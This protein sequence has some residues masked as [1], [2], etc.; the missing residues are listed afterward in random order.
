MPV[1]E[2]S[3]ELTYLL[4]HTVSSLKDEVTC[5]RSLGLLGLEEATLA[6]AF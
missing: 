6:S 3:H 1:L 5:P 4:S 2:E